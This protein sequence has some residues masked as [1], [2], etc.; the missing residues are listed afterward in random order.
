LEDILV[1]LGVVPAGVGGGDGAVSLP[2]HFLPVVIDGR[3]VGGGTEAS[4]RAVAAQLRRL[5]TSVVGAAGGDGAGGLVGGVVVEPTLEVAFVPRMI[6]GGGPYPGLFL[7]SQ[8][9]RMCRP[10]LHLESGRH[11]LIGAMAQQFLEVS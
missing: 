9:A 3:V 10:V 4:V 8:G 6:G 1:S 5:K 2:H 7:F 11:E